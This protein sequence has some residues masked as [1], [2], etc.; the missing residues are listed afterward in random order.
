MMW[1]RLIEMRKMSICILV[2]GCKIDDQ[3]RRSLASYDKVGVMGENDD[4]NCTRGRIARV[5][6]VVFT[7][8]Q[9]TFSSHQ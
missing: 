3:R 6:D 8:Q 2:N 4:F 1:H 5:A 7:Q 9:L